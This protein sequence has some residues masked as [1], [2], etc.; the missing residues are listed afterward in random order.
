MKSFLK[1]ITTEC[2]EMLNL[3]RHSA[4]LADRVHDDNEAKFREDLSENISYIGF[5]KI[6]EK[7]NS[8]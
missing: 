8:E 1:R 4:V 7:S 2:K 5:K 3:C 6:K